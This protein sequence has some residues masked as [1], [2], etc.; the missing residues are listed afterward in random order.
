MI[1]ELKK[2]KLYVIFG[3]I[4]LTMLALYF[5]F[6]LEKEHIENSPGSNWLETDLEQDKSINELEENGETKQEKL[7]IDIKGA[8]MSPGV[9][10]ATEGERVIDVI[11]RA[12]GLLESADQ[13][14]I[15][16]ALKVTDEMVLYIPTVGEQISGIL[17]TAQLPAEKEGK[18]NIN[19]ADETELQSLPGIGVSKAAAI[20]E[21]RDK[22]GSF[23]KVEDIMEIS[24][25]GV[26]TFEKLK[27]HIMVK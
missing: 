17:D 24:G 6:P 5:F 10:E 20:I 14:N 3:I 1:D 13:R 16:F 11:K 12:G 15:N 8:I 23:K 18:V 27:D 26:K 25:I 9:Y 2:H 19:T 22:N 21:Y 4:I 7:W